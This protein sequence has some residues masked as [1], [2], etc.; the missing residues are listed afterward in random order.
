MA[1]LKATN[2]TVVGAGPSAIASQ[3]AF[4]CGDGVRTRPFA[5]VG[6]RP[7]TTWRPQTSVVVFPVPALASTTRWGARLTLRFAL[8][9][10]NFAA[11]P[12][13]TGAGVPAAVVAADRTG[14]A[15]L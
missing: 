15:G 11:S 3:T 2:P 9:A 12:L 4:C 1:E 14:L 10:A 6:G 5:S 8:S 13:D 7:L